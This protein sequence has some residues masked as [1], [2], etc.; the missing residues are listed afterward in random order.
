MQHTLE[1]AEAYRMR[2]IQQRDRQAHL[3]QH[4]ARC[5][6]ERELRLQTCE[7]LRLYLINK[8]AGG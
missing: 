4:K 8:E 2:L 5:E 7:V 3:G 6:T 1:T